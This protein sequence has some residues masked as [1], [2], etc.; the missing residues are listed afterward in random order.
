[1]TRVVPILPHTLVRDENGFL[2]WDVRQR[3][4]VGNFVVE[5]PRAFPL[6][7]CAALVCLL[8]HQAAEAAFAPAALV[9]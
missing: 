9:G 3:D 6:A 4:I 5:W 2:E 8:P 1:M 7:A